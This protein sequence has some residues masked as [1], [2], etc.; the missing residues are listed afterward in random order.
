M[1]RWNR[2]H[3]L[4]PFGGGM[5]I[6]RFLADTQLGPQDQ[7]FLDLVYRRT[8]ERLSL[9]DRGDDDPIC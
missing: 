8:L 9:V 3:T 1:P 5:T 4:V 7:Q 6:R 2:F